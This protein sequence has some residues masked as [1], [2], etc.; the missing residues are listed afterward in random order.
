MAEGTIGVNGGIEGER[1]VGMSATAT[2]ERRTLTGD[3][4]IRRKVLLAAPFFG[5]CAGDGEPGMSAFRVPLGE[6]RVHQLYYVRTY[7][8]T[9]ALVC[10]R[11]P[12]P[13][14]RGGGSNG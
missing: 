8:K 1:G 3:R 7:S 11:S 12:G 10:A 2:A 14:S 13:P 6:L 5:M 9:S 4:L